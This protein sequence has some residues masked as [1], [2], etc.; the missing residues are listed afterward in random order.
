MFITLEGGEGAGKTTLRQRLVQAFEQT[1]RAI[2]VTNEPGATALG[3]QIRSLLLSSEVPVTPMAE[4]CLFL[5]DR[6]QHLEELVRPALQRGTLVLCDRF[7]DS[8]IAYQGGGR[9][10]GI[11]TVTALCRQVCGATWPNLTLYLDID[12]EIG[13]ARSRR[14]SA[15]LDRLESEQLAF[16]QRVRAAF[17]NLASREPNRIRI[18]RAD[19]PAD[20][21]FREAWGL[22]QGA[23]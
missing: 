15:T 5:A 12:P 13:L 4:L 2:C 7:C 20:E 14:R 6:A 19:R 3:Q 1:G 21:V 22:I 16:H 23:L 9:Q 18:L 17:L 8:T 10:L 11:E